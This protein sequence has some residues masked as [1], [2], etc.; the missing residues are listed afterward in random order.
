MFADSDGSLTDVVY[1]IRKRSR[2][3]IVQVVL[4]FHGIKCCLCASDDVS[5]DFMNRF[6]RQMHGIG[7]QTPSPV[8]DEERLAF[9]ANAHGHSSE[10]AVAVIS[11]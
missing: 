8:R 9:A 1:Q 4:L 11:C 6:V 7:E 10:Q 5:N 2:G 3:D